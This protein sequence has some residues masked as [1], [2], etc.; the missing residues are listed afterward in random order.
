MG[1]RGTR[2]ARRQHAER[3][4]NPVGG[5]LDRTPSQRFAVTGVSPGVGQ[6]VVDVYVVGI[7]D[8]GDGR[9]QVI[10]ADCVLVEVDDDVREHRVHLGPVDALD[11]PE[12]LLERVDHRFGVRAVRAAHFDVRPAGCR[13]HVSRSGATGN[14]ISRTLQGR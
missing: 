10:D 6:D 12:R 11:L 2:A 9:Q 1:S 3:G 14:T 13:P 4:A 8:V 7:F 5:E